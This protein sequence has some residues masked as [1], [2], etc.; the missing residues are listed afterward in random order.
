MRGLLKRANQKSRVS[1]SRKLSKIPFRKMWHIGLNRLLSDE[2]LEL[3]FRRFSGI[4]RIDWRR[5]TRRRRNM[6]QC[7]Q[8]SLERL[9]LRLS[10]VKAVLAVTHKPK[11]AEACDSDRKVSC[12]AGNHSVF[13]S[14]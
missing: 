6:F 2:R 11:L 8:T 10:L 7:R 5:D 14:E 12:A 4:V 9:C 3:G 13:S 1:K